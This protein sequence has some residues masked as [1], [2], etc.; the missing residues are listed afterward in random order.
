[1][2]ELFTHRFSS[3]VL[4]SLLIAAVP[5][6]QEELD[7]GTEGE[8]TSGI[9]EGTLFS[10]HTLF[11]NMCTELHPVWTQLISDRYGSHLLRTVLNILSGGKFQSISGGK[12]LVRSKSSRQY[13]E[14]HDL[15]KDELVHLTPDVPQAFKDM[16]EEVVHNISKNMSDVELRSFSCHP[17]A[18]PVLQAL[19]HLQADSKETLTMLIDR[20]LMGLSEDD[21]MLII[22]Y[23]S[24]CFDLNNC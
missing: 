9:D 20:L 15:G 3:H 5:I 18:N 16:L 22:N 14:N 13:V 4:Q 19:L 7:A 21:G 11:L 10:M 1:M 2:Y 6:I 8:G 24:I 17:V 23:F 12:N